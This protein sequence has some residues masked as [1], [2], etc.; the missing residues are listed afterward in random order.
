MEEVLTQLFET[1]SEEDRFSELEVS[2]YTINFCV[3]R[4][5]RKRE[6]W[7]LMNGHDMMSPFRAETRQKCREFD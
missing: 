6:K 4:E 2:H 5:E 7:N 3:A 1:K